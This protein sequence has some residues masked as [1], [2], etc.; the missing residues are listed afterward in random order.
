MQQQSLK[1]ESAMK[2]EKPKEGSPLNYTQ[3]LHQSSNGSV[4]GSTHLQPPG[5]PFAN[6]RRKYHY[7]TIATG[8]PSHYRPSPSP[9]HVPAPN[10]H[11]VAMATVSPTPP[12]HPPAPTHHQRMVL[13][14]PALVRNKYLG[15]ATLL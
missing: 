2:L 13:Q 14:P 7:I 15:T 12:Q 8:N 9:S 10:A 6:R 5:N 11:Q 4:G 1:S 3:S